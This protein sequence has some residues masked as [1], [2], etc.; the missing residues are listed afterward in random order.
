M[1]IADEDLAEFMRLYKTEFGEDV[2]VDEAREMARNLLDLYELL[3]R[4][5]PHEQPGRTPAEVSAT[6]PDERDA[7]HESND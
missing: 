2:S 6:T 5:L 4:P 7:R 3:A 1:Q